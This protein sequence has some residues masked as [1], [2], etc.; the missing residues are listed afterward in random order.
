MVASEGSAR[1]CGRAEA[2]SASSAA[3]ANGTFLPLRS[4]ASLE[5]LKEVDV[6]E[7]QHLGLADGLISLTKEVVVYGL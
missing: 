4:Y 6:Y 3:E 5:L 7:P 1:F 2:T